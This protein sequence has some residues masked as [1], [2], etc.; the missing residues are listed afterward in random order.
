[1]RRKGILI[2]YFAEAIHSWMSLI[3]EYPIAV[4]LSLFTRC[5]ASSVPGLE[6]SF[7]LS[8]SAIHHIGSTSLGPILDICSL[9]KSW[10]LR[11][12][13][14]SVEIS[15][16]LLFIISPIH[17]SRSTSITISVPDAKLV[18]REDCRMVQRPFTKTANR[19]R[20]T[21]DTRRTW[22]QKLAKFDLKT[23]LQLWEKFRVD[24]AFQS[25]NVAVEVV[26]CLLC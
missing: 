21:A 15:D 4:N 3:A 12:P 1:M 11:Q 19:V 10:L 5:S 23:N 26:D 14:D 8:I 13:T 2:P 6:T 25:P 22:G 9:K 20:G 16:Y 18:S 24:Q 7:L 17:H